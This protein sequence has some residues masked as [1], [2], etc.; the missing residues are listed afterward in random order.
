[1]AFSAFIIYLDP[2]HH[3]SFDQRNFSA[4]AAVNAETQPRELRRSGC[5]VLSP[6]RDI[7]LSTLVP[8]LREH[9]RERKQQEPER[10]EVLQNAVFWPWLLHP[11]THRSWGYV[12]SIKPVKIPAWMED[13]FLRPYL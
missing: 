1:M 2:V 11:R 13:E 6:K 12:H 8:R 10:E 7:S 4:V 5:W 3:D 9:G